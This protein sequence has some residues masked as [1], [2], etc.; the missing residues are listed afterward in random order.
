MLN[1]KI[2]DLFYSTKREGFNELDFQMYSHL[3]ETKVEFW[4]QYQMKRES[5]SG[6]NGQG[7][8]QCTADI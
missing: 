6:S 5:S 3:Q 8:P 4:N 1:Y 7:M 2:L